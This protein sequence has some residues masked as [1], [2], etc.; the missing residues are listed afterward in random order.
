MSRIF[1]E[2]DPLL[3]SGA[4]EAMGIK[5]TPE[6]EHAYSRRMMGCPCPAIAAMINHSYLQVI[7]SVTSTI[8]AEPG[9]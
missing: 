9:H 8:Q 4:D 5:L 6:E 1:S 3:R 7:S 2:A